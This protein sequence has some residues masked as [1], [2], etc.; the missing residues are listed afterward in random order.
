MNIEN[1]DKELNAELD[2]NLNLKGQ[3]NTLGSTKPISSTSTP[4]MAKATTIVKLN[5]TIE[6]LQQNIEELQAMIRVV[7]EIKKRLV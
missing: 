4:A 5:Q 6:D 1:M 2:K 3:G 7:E